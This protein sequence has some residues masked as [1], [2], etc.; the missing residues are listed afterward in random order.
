MGQ[1]SEELKA[2]IEQ[3]RENM[4]ET[5]DAIEDRVVPGRIIERPPPSRSAN[6]PV[7]CVIA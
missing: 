5:I 6:G 7:G 3:R 2:D 4:S 1:E